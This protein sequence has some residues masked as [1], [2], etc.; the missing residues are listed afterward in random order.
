MKS[1]I[2]CGASGFV[3]HHLC[4]E[5]SA[6][7]YK[8]YALVRENSRNKQ[9][10][11]NLKNTSLICCDLEN[12][13]NLP[14]LV[15][16]DIDLF[17]NLA[18]SGSAGNKRADYVLQLDN[19]RLACN[20]LRTADRM[21]CRRFVGI[22]S[23]MEDECR[24]FVPADGQK[25]VPDCVY[26]CAKLTAHYMCKSVAAGLDLEL[27]WARLSN[28]YGEDDNT[29]RFINNVLHKMKQGITCDLTNAGQMYDFI[30]VTEAAR[31]LR[32]IG[33]KGKAD[34]SYFIG[35]MDARPLREFIEIMQKIINPDVQ[36]NFGAVRSGGVDMGKAYF[37][38]ARMLYEH[39][40][41]K[42]GVSFEEGIKRTLEK[43]L[44]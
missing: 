24:I 6:N 29:D 25:A 13:E 1:A 12:I 43:N 31:A 23:I 14:K 33:E 42:S 44:I 32:Y 11:M 20:A 19:V 27:C 35:S 34:Y 36:L 3:G 10:L 2:V 5:L 37:D 16:D 39:T 7:G 17:Y 18:W 30:Y 38:E 22:G 26:G 28:A 8:V 15:K 9:F 4:A 40:G 41:F 21:R